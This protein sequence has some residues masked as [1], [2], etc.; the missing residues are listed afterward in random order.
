MAERPAQGDNAS[1]AEPNPNIRRYALVPS[2]SGKGMRRFHLARVESARA[3]P[4]PQR[5]ERMEDVAA[6]EERG[7][8]AG[9]IGQPG[10]D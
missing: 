2:D 3:V 7:R 1:V 6:K 9:D 10:V 4:G 8:E 5:L